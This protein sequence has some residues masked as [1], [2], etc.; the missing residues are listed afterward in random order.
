[1]HFTD[2]FL[3]ERSWPCFFFLCFSSFNCRIC[4][5]TL[6]VKLPENIS[7]LKNMAWCFN[8]WGAKNRHIQHVLGIVLDDWTLSLQHLSAFGQE[9]QPFSFQWQ[10]PAP[11]LCQWIG[12]K[13][14]LQKASLSPGPICHQSF[15][16]LNGCLNIRGSERSL[17]MIHF[18]QKLKSLRGTQLQ[19]NIP[20]NDG[21]IFPIATEK[22]SHRISHGHLAK[23][24]AFTAL[25]AAALH[26]F[27]ARG[28]LAFHLVEPCFSEGYLYNILIWSGHRKP[29]VIWS[30]NLPWDHPNRLH[31]RNWGLKEL[32]RRHT[33]WL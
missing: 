9:K 5:R 28:I 14:I 21:L 32:N 10:K 33:C 12:W 1:M 27:G 30:G 18:T 8:G 24:M 2:V 26:R 7:R 23:P 6:L 25:H 19:K 16:I 13:S 15:K 29:L 22:T 17:K 11:N 20:W 31:I 3:A 4:R